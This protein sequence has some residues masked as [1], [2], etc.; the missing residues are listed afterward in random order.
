MLSTLDGCESALFSETRAAAAFS[1]VINPE[2]SPEFGTRKQG[3]SLLFL[4]GLYSR[5][6]REYEMLASSLTY[7]GREGRRENRHCY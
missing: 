1:Q 7:L 4:S 3:S 5:I 2:H 6:S